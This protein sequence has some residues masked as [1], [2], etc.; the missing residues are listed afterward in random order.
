M[1][2]IETEAAKSELESILCGPPEEYYLTQKAASIETVM[3]DYAKLWTTQIEHAQR[4]ISLAE[5]LRSSPNDQILLQNVTAE[6]RSSFKKHS[7]RLS[8]IDKHLAAAV[9]LRSEFLIRIETANSMLD[10]SPELV[11]QITDRNDSLWK[12]IR[13]LHQKFESIKA[14]FISDSDFIFKT[15]RDVKIPQRMKLR[16]AYTAFFCD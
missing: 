1:G 13:Q 5:Q 11:K 14:Q 10:L 9:K 8:E 16:D 7:R 2:Q 6:F 4:M 12:D 15:Q 3:R